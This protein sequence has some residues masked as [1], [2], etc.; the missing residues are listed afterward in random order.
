[1]KIRAYT[2]IIIFCVLF[3][4]F[5]TSCRKDGVSVDTETEVLTDTAVVTEA[6]TTAP[7]TETE[8]AQ[9]EPVTEAPDESVRTPIENEKALK[10]IE[11]QYGKAAEVIDWV[12]NGT[13]KVNFNAE[14]PTEDGRIFFPVDDKTERAELDG[15]SIATFA[16]LSTYI[17]SIFA[18][19]IA[20]D[21]IDLA[22][23]HYTDIDGVLCKEAE[24]VDTEPDIE[25]PEDTEDAEDGSEG[26]EEEAAQPVVVSTEFF[27][28]KFTDTL[29]RY[30]A[31][32][33]Y[34]TAE[35]E[36]EAS[37]VQTE[38]AEYFDFI[39]ENTGSGWYFTAFPTLPQ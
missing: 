2:V 19:S 34:E 25:L 39:F 14:I 1:M 20:D 36:E 22:A 5:V 33:T 29:L 24:Y 35:N 26:E 7:V 12:K 38:N 3:A 9:T 23:E 10:F 30:T 16:D 18:R 6:V 32:V 31:K 37:E 15:A 17:K 21:L 28:S 8:P 13:L 27:L 4:L 11:Y